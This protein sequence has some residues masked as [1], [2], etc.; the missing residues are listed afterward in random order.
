MGDEESERRRIG[1]ATYYVRSEQEANDAHALARLAG[2]QRFA[3]LVFEAVD[4]KLAQL[5]EQFGPALEAA[6]AAREQQG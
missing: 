1:V 4:A 3:H 6:R 5:R 2:Y